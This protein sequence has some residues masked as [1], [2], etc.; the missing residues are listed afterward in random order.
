MLWDISCLRHWIG[1]TNPTTGKSMLVETLGAVLCDKPNN[2]ACIES[3]LHGFGHMIGQFPK[4]R[5]QM[6][7]EIDRFITTRPVL[8]PELSAYAAAAYRGCVQ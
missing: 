7:A 4:Y 8:R 5:E 3:V 1:T 2:P 6:Q